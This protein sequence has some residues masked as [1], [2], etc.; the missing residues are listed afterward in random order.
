M[1]ARLEGASESRGHL[2]DAFDTT[3]NLRVVLAT[4][5][6]PACAAAIA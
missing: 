6:V 3:V 5:P 2:E 4:G 1:G